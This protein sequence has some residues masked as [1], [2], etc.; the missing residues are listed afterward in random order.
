MEGSKWKAVFM[1][2]IDQALATAEYKFLQLCYFRL[3]EALKAIENL[4]HC[5]A[6]YQIAKEGLERNFGGQR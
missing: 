5:A 2:C 4:G 1:A 6:A 3:G